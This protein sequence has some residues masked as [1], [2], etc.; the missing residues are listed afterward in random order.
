MIQTAQSPRPALAEEVMRR[1]T[2]AITPH[3]DAGKTT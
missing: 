2:F 1:R 3:P